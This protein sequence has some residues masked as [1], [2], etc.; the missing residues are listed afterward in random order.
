MALSVFQKVES[1]YCCAVFFPSQLTVKPPQWT[2]KWVD[3]PE[4]E[5]LVDNEVE[6]AARKDTN[7]TKLLL[8]V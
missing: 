4:D 3:E 6:D 1:Q 7:T 5:T 2:E 8:V